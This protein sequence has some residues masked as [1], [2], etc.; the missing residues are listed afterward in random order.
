MF[1]MD[2][3]SLVGLML[4]LIGFL[5]ASLVWFY[6]H[7]WLMARAATKMKWELTQ[8]LP[9]SIEEIEADKRL[10]EARHHLELQHLQT[11]IAEIKLK[12]AEAEAKVA[13]SLS[14]I[15]RLN[16]KIELLYLELVAKGVRDKREK[17]KDKEVL[18]DK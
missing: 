2:Q 7:K 15:D 4:V 17:S 3:H 1:G 8:N 12:E 13:D 9:K 11:R 6:L 14:K 5:A 16:H 18:A 10:V